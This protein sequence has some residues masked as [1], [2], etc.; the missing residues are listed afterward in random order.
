LRTGVISHIQVA[1]RGQPSAEPAT[2]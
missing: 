2:K 1:R